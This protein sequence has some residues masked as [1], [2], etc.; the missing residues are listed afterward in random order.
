MLTNVIE[1]T[2]SLVFRLLSWMEYSDPARLPQ[3]I[4]IH[5]ADQG[6]HGPCTA[7]PGYDHTYD[8][9]SSILSKPLSRVANG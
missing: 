9:S 5:Q 8:E 3:P 7:I 1:S 2:I 6:G 4:I